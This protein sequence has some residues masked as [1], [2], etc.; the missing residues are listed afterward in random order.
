MLSQEERPNASMAGVKKATKPEHGPQ[1]KH[2]VQ[3][4]PLDTQKTNF[5]SAR[6]MINMHHRVNTARYMSGNSAMI[7]KKTEQPKVNLKASVEREKKTLDQN[8]EK[9]NKVLH[10]LKASPQRYSINQKVIGRSGGQTSSQVGMTEK[11]QATLKN[12]KPSQM[13]SSSALS[14]SVA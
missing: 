14:H 1:F 7:F 2:P 9:F 3:K 6:A 13:Y 8:I 11:T 4:K 10:S 12:S 5:D